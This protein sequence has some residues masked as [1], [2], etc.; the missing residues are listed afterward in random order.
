MSFSKVQHPILLAPSMT[1]CY[2][3]ITPSI[4]N[5]HVNPKSTYDNE[6]IE[7][8]T[9]KKSKALVIQPPTS[10]PTRVT[11]VDNNMELKC[12]NPSKLE[13]LDVAIKDHSLNYAGL[14]DTADELAKDHDE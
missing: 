6:L 7:V 8:S 12:S 4:D 13:N 10:K 3:N 5:F 11:I 1:N 2:H 9:P 14:E